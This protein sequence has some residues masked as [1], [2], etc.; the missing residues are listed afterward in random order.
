MLGAS[1]IELQGNESTIWWTACH[2]R[3]ISAGSAA[4][5]ILARQ[6]GTLGPPAPYP[7]TAPPNPTIVTSTINPSTFPWETP[8]FTFRA[9]NTE[10]NDTAV[11][12]M[13]SNDGNGATPSTGY[14]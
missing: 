7:I 2:T 10:F 8:G 1:P 3:V 11:T 9:E 13:A 5:S 14:A 12:F 4:M 6:F